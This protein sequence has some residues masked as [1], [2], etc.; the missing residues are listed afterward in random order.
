MGNNNLLLMLIDALWQEQN[1]QWQMM[2]KGYQ[3]FSHIVTKD[4]SYGGKVF[5]AQHNPRRIVSASANVDKQCV[6]KRPCFLCSDSFNKDQKGIL[7]HHKYLFLINPYPILPRHFTIPSLKH[8][9]QQIMG[10]TFTDMA[11][12]AEM[13]RNKYDVYFNGATAG[14]SAP[15]HFHFQAGPQGILP[16]CEMDISQPIWQGQHSIVSEIE[17]SPRTILLI[18]STEIEEMNK[19]WQ[20]I[21]NALSEPQRINLVMR[22]SK[23]SW[24]LWIILR[25]K[26]RPECYTA[27][28]DNKMMVSPGVIDMAGIAVLPRQ[29]D[30]DRINGEI[31]Y[32]IMAEVSLSVTDYRKTLQ[33]IK[34]S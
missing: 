1:N 7:L 3:D 22:H 23:G 29:F 13:L 8:E 25:S 9:P 12:M 4:I 14:A 16:L 6:A 21:Y 24:K 10:D 2:Q 15:D 34:W 18:Q 20:S 5:R 31:W 11:W 19:A 33:R 30:F 26:H 28:G 32:R 27:E 17:T